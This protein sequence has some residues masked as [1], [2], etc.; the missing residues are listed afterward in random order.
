MRQ[1]L[2]T[3]FEFARLQATWKAEIL[4]GFITFITMAHIVLVNPAILQEAGMPLAAVPRRASLPP[5][6]TC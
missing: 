2:E 5:S 4:A 1:R 3:F 6:A